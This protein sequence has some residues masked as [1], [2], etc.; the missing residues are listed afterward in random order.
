LIIRERDAFGKTSPQ[1]MESSHKWKTSD[2]IAENELN[3][4]REIR[5]PK[6]RDASPP[7]GDVLM[8]TSRKT[9]GRV[10]GVK[11]FHTIS[12]STETVIMGER[13]VDG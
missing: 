8:D 13:R 12:P 10:Q 4:Q 6:A 7:L 2:E 11:Q 9:R 1:G 3:A 5:R